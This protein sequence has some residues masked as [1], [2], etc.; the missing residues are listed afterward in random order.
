MNARTNAVQTGFQ[1]ARIEFRQTVTSGQEVWSMLFLPLVAL[2]V[3]YLLRGKTV[4]GT[5]FSLGSQAVPG[6]LGMNVVFAGMVALALAL[7][8]DRED[9]TLLRAKAVPHG[10]TGYLTGRVLSRAAT[11]VTG[12]LVPLVPALFLF[13]GVAL[14]GAA[15]LFTLVAVTVLGLLALLPLGA[16]FG[17]LTANPQALGFLTVPVMLLMGV[18]GIFHPVT[19]LP[20]WLQAAAQLFPLYWLGLGLRSALL[21]DALAAAELTGTWRPL[22]TYLALTLWAALSLTLT[23]LTLR[24]AH[25][26]P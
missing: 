7:C 5:G 15:S 2:T 24:R 26:T 11:A 3:M 19:A 4:P 13:D 17:S 12:M 8:T 6:I 23:S 9:G 14:T 1:R 18:S 25:R 16:L 20:G 22:P 21:P 10:L